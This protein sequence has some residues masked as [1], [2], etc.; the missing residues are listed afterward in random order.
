MS[1]D[2]ATTLL[3]RGELLR[4]GSF[5]DAD[6]TF[7]LVLGDGAATC[8]VDQQFQAE[9]WKDEETGS[10]DTTRRQFQRIDEIKPRMKKSGWLRFLVGAVL[11]GSG[12]EHRD[13]AKRRAGGSS[14]FYASRR[15]LPDRALFRCRMQIERPP[16]PPLLR[17]RS[18]SFL[19]DDDVPDE[20]T[21][22]LQ[23]VLSRMP[24]VSMSV[25]DGEAS[26]PESP[27]SPS[28]KPRRR[29]SITIESP[30]KLLLPGRGRFQPVRTTISI[31]LRL[32]QALLLLLLLIPCCSGFVVGGARAV[33]PA[34][35]TSSSRAAFS[36][37]LSSSVAPTDWATARPPSRAEEATRALEALTAN[38]GLRARIGLVRF[39]L[40]AEHQIELQHVG[41]AA[42]SP[43]KWLLSRASEA[44]CSLA[45]PSAFG[46]V[47]RWRDLR[48][49]AAQR[50]LQS[51]AAELEAALGAALPLGARF[52][53]D[54]RLK[55]TTSLFE[56]L[57]L[58]GKSDVHD[59]LGMRVILE[60]DGAA[61][62]AAGGCAARCHEAA[63]VVGQLWTMSRPVKDYVAAPKKNGYRS[64]HLTVQLTSGLT[65][66]VQVRTRC[67]HDTAE[68]GSAAH[69][70]YK[71][72]ELD[73]ACLAR[74]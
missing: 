21:T 41:A 4:T 71:S 67:M 9:R 58:R 44:A 40:G 46:D 30:R 26:E 34:G 31:D 16:R 6:E 49:P 36:P 47:K 39:C 32:V 53:I 42:R 2:A 38:K 13:A 22:P 48:A 18:E 65:A 59:A 57:V 54:S 5:I 8:I 28:P 45:F 68:C 15:A 10:G 12:M 27:G 23:K 14:L 60:A 33:P 69:G 37:A 52:T 64:I 74:A 63:A 29:L 73:R 25:E 55:S 61:E 17:V 56:K 35:R 24:S 51:S 70:L 62:H 11:G 20:P 1:C 72:E 3:P 50:A 43:Q 19:D 7:S 66:E